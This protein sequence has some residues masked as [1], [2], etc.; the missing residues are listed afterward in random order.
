[1]KCVI[2]AALVLVADAAVQ[3]M[4]SVMPMHSAMPMHMYQAMPMHKAMPM[5]SA[6]PVHM[7]S[8]MPMHMH[9]AMPMA[10]ARWGQPAQAMGREANAEI[11]EHAVDMSEPGRYMYRFR[12]NNGIAMMEQYAMDKDAAK[13]QG[14]Y[15]WMS[16]EGEN[17]KVEYVADEMGYR[18]VGAHLPQVPVA[19]LRSLEWNAAHPEEDMAGKY[20]AEKMMH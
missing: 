9:K 14:A 10:E 18:P 2:V 1:M 16:P 13:V 15:E 12:T 19:I 4:M 20:H 3:P 11:V 6:M 7:H 5:Y 17:Y 8:A